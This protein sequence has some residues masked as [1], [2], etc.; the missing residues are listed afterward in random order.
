MAEKTYEELQAE[1]ERLRGPFRCCKHCPEDQIHDVEPNA[2]DLPCTICED[3]LR[4]RAE[5]AEAKVARVEALDFRGLAERLVKAAT[6]VD[7]WR[8]GGWA[9]QGARIDAVESALRAVL[10]DAPAEQQATRC[11]AKHPDYPGGGER[12]TWEPDHVGN[13][14]NSFVGEWPAE[15]RAEGGA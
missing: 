3:T 13:H 7:E 11:G 6:S 14:W 5:A 4:V 8:A 15:Q 1:V 2:H 12:C 10:A 9:R